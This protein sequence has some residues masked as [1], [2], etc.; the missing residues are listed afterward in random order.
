VR[1][2]VAIQRTFLARRVSEAVETY[3]HADAVLAETRG[4]SGPSRMHLRLLSGDDFFW[5]HVKSLGD[6]ASD[7]DV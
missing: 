3:A 7:A 2:N 1:D 5:R 4:R 6:D